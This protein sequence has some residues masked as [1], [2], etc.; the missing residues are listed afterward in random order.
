MKLIE[1][2]CKSAIGFACF[3][4][5]ICSAVVEGDLKSSLILIALS[6]LALKD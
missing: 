2:L 5:G 6:Y 4:V 3:L 1:R